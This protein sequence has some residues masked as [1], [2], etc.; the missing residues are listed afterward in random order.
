MTYV[1]TQKCIGCKDM[2][3]ATICPTESFHVGPDMLFINPDSCIDCHG[4]VVECPVEAIFHEDDIPNEFTS[5]IELNRE[6][7]PKYPLAT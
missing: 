2:S 3:C 1:V 5:D 7:A 6:M 4:C